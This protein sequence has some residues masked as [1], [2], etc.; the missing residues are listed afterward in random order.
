MLGQKPVRTPEEQELIVTMHQTWGDARR[1]ARTETQ[2]EAVLTVL[3]VRGIAIPATVLKRMLAEKDLEQLERRHEK[4]I[5]ATSIEE[6]IGS[7]R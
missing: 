6:V 3:R 5:V 2:A 4:A 1:D 7:R